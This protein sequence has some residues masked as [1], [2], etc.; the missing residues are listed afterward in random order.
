MSVR[1]MHVVGA[2]RTPLP[3]PFSPSLSASEHGGDEVD[4]PRHRAGTAS[5]G[6]S[7]WAR[8]RMAL[9]ATGRGCAVAS[10]FFV[11]L[12]KPATN[13]ALALGI[14]CSLLGA[15]ARRRWS[16][17]AR[18]PVARGALLWCAVLMLSACHAWYLPGSFP[19]TG[20]YVWACAYPLAFASLLQD[21]PWRRRAMA[22]FAAATAIVMLVSFGMGLGL[23]P[24]RAEALASP[25]L[26][27][28]VFKEYTQQG[29]AT[30][31]LACMAAATAAAT[32]SKALQRL[33]LAT[34]G[35]AL[36][37]VT[38]VLESRTT[39]LTLLPL[40][41]YW[42]WWGVRR[43]QLDWRLLLA[44]LLAAMAVLALAWSTPVVQKRLVGAIP[45]EIG[46]YLHEH[47]ATSAGIRLELWRRTVPIIA[48][49]PLLGHGLHQW[50]PLYE[51]SIAGLPDFKAFDMG[52]PH[53]EMLL[54]AAEQGL[55]G[56]AIYLAL[57]LALA[58][59]TRH[60]EAPER[61]FY[62]CLLLIYLVAG[63]GNGLWADF[64]HRHAFILL[65][66]CIPL[67]MRRRPAIHV[68]GPG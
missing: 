35:L 13:V 32:R 48:S 39:Y 3:V 56:L 47:Q 58:R 14:L 30:L 22:A 10:L 6:T 42:A 4:S 26:H 62:Q 66:A 11:P 67:A 59:Y 37:N 1:R 38:M 34:A 12:N 2:V 31:M 24:Q 25:M 41:V 16:E 17:A 51:A 49:A 53:Q 61:Y 45:Q 8:V 44:A 5:P 28:T 55:L 23:I 40:V 64:T 43:W 60:L 63:L 36:L 18:H 65:L 19:R 54:I 7:W 57:L 68:P 33:C 20:T 50:A 9:L 46:L 29:L 21:T 15:D 52:H 27:N